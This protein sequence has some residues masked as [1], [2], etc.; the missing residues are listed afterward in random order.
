MSWNCNPH[1][2]SEL[3]FWP[4]LPESLSIE[5]F[6]VCHAPGDTIHIEKSP[7]SFAKTQVKQQENL[8]YLHVSSCAALDYLE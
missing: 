2:N 6:H 1:G 8:Y 5:H 3:V 4:C 7:F